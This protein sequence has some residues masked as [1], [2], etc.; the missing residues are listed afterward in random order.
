VIA[1]FDTSALIPLLI[2]EPGSAAAERVWDVADRLVSVRLM[3]TEAR[4]AVAQA[5]RL[6]RL[7]ANQLD[8]V[9]QQLDEL[10]AQLDRLEIDESLVRRAGELAQSH[11]LRGYDAVHLAGLER[12]ADE[13]TVLVSGDEDLCIA[14][15][16]L[17]VATVSTSDPERAAA[18]Q[19]EV[20]SD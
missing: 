18:E 1:Y 2:E 13:D 14:A 3:Y 5:H 10:Y 17:G 9:V 8:T 7:D 16:G 20:G 12:V 15:Q 6:G 19:H 11:A 4:A